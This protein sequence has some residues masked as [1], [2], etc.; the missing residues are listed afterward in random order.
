MVKL[1]EKPEAKEKPRPIRLSSKDRQLVFV[2]A[3][4]GAAVGWL[5][6]LIAFA[7]MTSPFAL[8][9]WAEQ[10]IEFIG[11]IVLFFFAWILVSIL[12]RILEKP[13]FRAD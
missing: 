6:N 8:P 3:I 10:V 2:G 11:R 1:S 12:L 13:F 5:L 4:V 9:V 7:P